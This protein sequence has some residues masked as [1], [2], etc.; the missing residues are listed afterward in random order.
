LN[1]FPISSS[2]LKSSSYTYLKSGV[3]QVI[4]GADDTPNSSVLRF[5]TTNNLSVSVNGVLIDPV[6]YDRSVLNQIT[7]TPAIYESNNLITIIV[8]NDLLVNVAD[9]NIVDLSFSVINDPT[10]L[11]G[12]SWGNY[13]AVEIQGQTRYMMHCTDL[14]MLMPDI[15]YGIK[16]AQLIDSNIITVDNITPGYYYKIITIGDNYPISNFISIG[17]ASNTAGTI[18]QANSISPLLDGSTGKVSQVI[19]VDLSEFNLLTAKD[20]YGFQDKELHAYLSGSLFNSSFSF[21]YSQDLLTGIYKLTALQSLFTQLTNILIPS[22]SS[23]SNLT[24]SIN[25]ASTPATGLKHKYIIGP[26]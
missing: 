17:A 18:F 5:E 16:G 10:I 11:S 3:V 13:D 20:P 12:C 26:T 2:L 23:S 15:A 8:Y 1:I 24:V 9:E 25:G 7:F 22:I 21:T 4:S 6:N 14:S 19:D